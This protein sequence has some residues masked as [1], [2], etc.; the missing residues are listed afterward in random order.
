[1]CLYIQSLRRDVYIA[2]TKELFLR[3]DK[4]LEANAKA[5]HALI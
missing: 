3:N 2:T 1:M 4:S 5:V